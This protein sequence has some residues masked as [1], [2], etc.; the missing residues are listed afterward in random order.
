MTESEEII[1]LQTQLAHLQRHIEAQDAEMYKMSLRVDKLSE[2]LKQQNAQIKALNEQ[3]GG[4][5]P[6]DEKPPHY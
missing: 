1:Q 5:M 3:G 2:L 4:D 6:A